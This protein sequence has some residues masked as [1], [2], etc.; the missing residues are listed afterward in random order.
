[1][2]L[3]LLLDL[4][5]TLLVNENDRFLPAYFQALSKELAHIV[6]PKILV[7]SL[8]SATS[9]MM[10]NQ[11]PEH[12]LKDVFDAAFYP[13]IGL[14]SQDMQEEFEH[15]YQDIFPGLQGLTQAKPEAVKLVE[16]AF[17][18]GYR[19]AIATD[20]LY[21]RTAIEQ[22]LTWAGLPPDIYPF[23]LIPSYEIFHFTK[24]NPAYYAE[25]L[26]YMGWPEG[27]VLMVGDNID[28]DISGA[29]RL[30]LA[31]FWV[32]QPCVTPPDSPGT[33]TGHGTLDRILPWIDQMSEQELQPEYNMPSAILATLRSTPA[34][35]SNL[36]SP[37]TR[38]AWTKRPKPEEWCPTEIVYHLR[39]VERDV[40]LPRLEKVLH[41]EN[42]F[43]AGKDTD[44]WAEQR[45]YRSQDGPLG[46]QGFIAARKEVLSLLDPL[47]QQSWQRPA[48][49]AI[50]GPTTVEELAGI[51]AGHDR[52]HIQQIKDAIE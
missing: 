33:P 46:L 4:D 21:P 26:A 17:D 37:L 15:F 38:T 27:P 22:R 16:A 3:T 10:L 14:S 32:P 36:C 39:D 29:A 30:G 8:L 35:L 7:N 1:M 31:T 34:A 11:Q 48:R 50:F 41:E 51:I 24:P 18:R 49:H 43:L 9:Q 52:L 47:P 19:V 2:S 5:N 20:P 45:D 25:L 13:D 12:T 42:P 44:P 28:K 6:E 23:A 40:N